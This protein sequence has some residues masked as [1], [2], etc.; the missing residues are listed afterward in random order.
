MI[1]NFEKDLTQSEEPK[2]YENA[3]IAGALYDFLGFLT[4][5]K[6]PVTMSARHQSGIAVDLLQR[7][8]EERGFSIKSANVKNWNHRR[9]TY[10]NIATHDFWNSRKNK[11]WWSVSPEVRAN[12]RISSKRIFQ[13]N[14]R[15]Y[16][17]T[18]LGKQKA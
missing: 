9:K 13:K 6:E 3:D 4:T 10:K 12:Q 17:R 8:A 16:E 18:F 11:V 1:M 5:L 14:C 7:W 15:K 2:E